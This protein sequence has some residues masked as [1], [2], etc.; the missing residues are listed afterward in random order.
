MPEDEEKKLDEIREYAH[1]AATQSPFSQ[2]ISD[3]AAEQAKIM[4]ETGP[5][6]TLGIQMVLTIGVFFGIGYWLD[7]HFGTSPL[8]TAILSAS[9]AVAG[10]I[11]FIVTV[12]RLQKSDDARRKRE[13]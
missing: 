2:K 9:G 13:G 6:L 10:L 7:K 11:Y 4:R 8:W 5:Y 1:R 3:Q 12:I